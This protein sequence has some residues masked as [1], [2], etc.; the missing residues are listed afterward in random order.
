MSALE[1]LPQELLLH[2]VLHLDQPSAERLLSCCR[3]L[4]CDD[5][6]WDALARA[7]WGDAF[8][9]AALAR[10]MLWRSHVSM[11]EELREIHRHEQALRHAGWPLWTAADYRVWWDCEAAMVRRGVAGGKGAPSTRCIG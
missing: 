3:A 7:R 8:W 9:D 4:R 6:F 11:R 2:T 1:L 5:A 10:P